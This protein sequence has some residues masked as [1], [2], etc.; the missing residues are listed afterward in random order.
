MCRQDVPVFVRVL[1]LPGHTQCCHVPTLEHLAPFR[2]RIQLNVMGQYAPDFLINATDGAL[3][4][5]PRR[6]EVEEVRQA[7]SV[8]GFSFA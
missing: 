3:A 2:D 1:V 4:R 5:R 6:D 8:A 7:A